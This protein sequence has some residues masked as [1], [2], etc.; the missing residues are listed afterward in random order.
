MGYF[1]RGVL[2]NLEQQNLVLVE[3]AQAGKLR[4]TF[5]GGVR[6]VPL[7]RAFGGTAQGLKTKKKEY[8]VAKNKLQGKKKEE[9]LFVDGQVIESLPNRMF[10]VVIGENEQEKIIGYLSGKMT[11]NYIRVTIGDWVRVEFSP[12][13]LSKGRIV[14]RYSKPPRK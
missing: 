8:E 14:F 7:M 11:K 6:F 1:C 9:K 5:H 4:E 12:Y 13:D 2:G 10:R 3:R